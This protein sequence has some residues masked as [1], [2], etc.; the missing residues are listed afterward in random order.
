MELILFSELFTICKTA[1]TPVLPAECVP[2]FSA[3][4]G[5]EYSLVC[6]TAFVPANCLQRED[7]W[8]LLRIAGTLDFSLTGILHAVTGTLARESISVF[9]VS[10]YNTDYLLVRQDQLA[11][12]IAAWEADGYTITEK[13]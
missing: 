13:K 10:T 8:R 7:D 4:T 1:K 2:V 9:A 5:E 11:K 3:N 12:A 6:P